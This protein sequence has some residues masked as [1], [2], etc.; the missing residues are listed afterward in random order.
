MP[1][2]LRKM[3]WY[4]IVFKSLDFYTIFLYALCNNKI[5]TSLGP[6]NNVHKC[7]F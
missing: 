2:S 4:L 1:K 7:D 3:F 5:Q 6:L